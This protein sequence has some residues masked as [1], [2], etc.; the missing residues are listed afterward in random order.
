MELSHEQSY[1]GV[2]VFRACGL[3]KIFFDFFLSIDK[4]IILRY[5]VEKGVNGHYESRGRQA[6]RRVM[7]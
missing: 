3:K 4:N 2:G 5:N 7:G 6:K 1:P